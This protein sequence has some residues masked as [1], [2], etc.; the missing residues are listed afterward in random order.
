M[1]VLLP[2]QARWWSDDSPIKVAEK[3]R[4]IGLTWTTA[5]RSAYD[6]GRRGKRGCDSWY[7]G[8]NE[9]MAAEF[10]R[11]VGWWAKR[12]GLLVKSSEYL[13]AD[14]D[15]SILTYSVRFA[16]GRRVSALTSSPRNL[17][18][19]SGNVIIDEAAHHDDLSGLL[20]AA[21]AARI[22]GGRVTVIST[23]ESTENYFNTIVSETKKG[24][25][26]Y[27]LHTIDFD[28]AL[29]D[30][31]YR[32]ICLMTEQPWSDAAEREW[33]QSVIDDYHPFADEELFCKP[34]PPGRRGYFERE[35]FE[36]VDQAPA[37]RAIV[38]G[39]DLAATEK[40]KKNRDPDWTRG[41]KIG[42]SE[43][44]RLFVLDG[45][46]I[47]GSP[48][49][50]GSLLTATAT[51]DGHD[52]TQAF[53]QD[54]GQAGKDQAAT[55]R[56][57]LSGFAVRFKP[58]TRSKLSYAAPFSSMANSGRV[59][60]VKGQWNDSWFDE[61][62]SF[63]DGPHD[64]WVDA[65]SRAQIELRLHNRGGLNIELGGSQLVMP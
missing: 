51:A 34:R 13:L 50:V 45:C 48:G 44:G 56:E 2:Y 52:T 36:M 57:L 7:I 60:V 61:L 9:E 1:S 28:D 53:W 37:L 27:S 15:N 46:G 33:R 26:A 54:P 30:G 4:R 6:A 24:K 3:S 42:R 38:R 65:T 63:P 43:S 39:W 10:V 14:G 22:W 49:A 59:S 40:S 62:E 25:R 47:Q 32:R 8:Y 12:F 18:G 58:A 55:K 31:L 29:T 5:G 11:D 17:R 16:T 64:D 23:H 21:I 20:K 19:K 35:W 41:V